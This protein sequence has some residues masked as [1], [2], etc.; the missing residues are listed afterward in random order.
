MADAPRPPWH[1]EIVELHEFFEGYFLGTLPLDAL[2]RAEAAFHPEF[3]MTAPDGET[4]N[5]ATIVQMLHDGHHH[6]DDLTITT[7][8]HT[9]VREEGD[10]L[11][12]TYVER[13]DL[14]DGRSNERQTMVV[15]VAD[16]DAPNGLAWRHAQETWIGRDG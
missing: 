15:F 7:S 5:R 14:R 10:T 8:D 2:D 12:A 6:T 3:T 11:V 13:H 4:R 9:L 16:P 1:A